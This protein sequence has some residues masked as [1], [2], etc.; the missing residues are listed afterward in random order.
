V[1]LS[2][3]IVIQWP[4]RLFPNQDPRTAAP[5]FTHGGAHAGVHQFRAP[6]LPALIPA[7]IHDKE[8]DLNMVGLHTAAG[9]RWRGSTTGSS[10][11]RA[12]AWISGAAPNPSSN[13]ILRPPPQRPAKASPIDTEFNHSDGTIP[14]PS[15]SVFSPL[16]NGGTAAW[17]PVVAPVW[18]TQEPRQRAP[19]TRLC[20]PQGPERRC[21]RETTATTAA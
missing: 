6:M 9:R 5:P 11:H 10:G 13:P 17:L 14:P 1:I 21:R 19:V 8:S 7:T 16:G 20:H 2:R 15:L 12:P 4:A 18:D 3:P